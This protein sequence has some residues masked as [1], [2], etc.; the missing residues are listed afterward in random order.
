MSETPENDTI[1]AL[2]PISFLSALV[3]WAVLYAILKL[4][5]FNH[6]FGFLS[7]NQAIV[8][9]LHGSMF[10]IYFC[11]MVILDIK[12]FKANS[13]HGGFLLLL[14]YE[15]SVMTHLAISLNRLCAV[16][17]PHRYPNIFS[18]RNTKIIIAFIW[19]YTSSVAV[20]FYEVSCS[21][22][23]DEEI[24]FL[25]FSKTKL[26]GYIGWYGDLL[27][28]S[29]IVAIVMVLDM[30]TVVKVRKMSRKISAN[31]SDQAQNRLSQREMRFLKQTVTQ[32]TVF[33]LE[34][35]SYFFIPQYFVNKW[36]L[37]F[38]TSFAWVA[39][40]AL[41]GIWKYSIGRSSFI[42]NYPIGEQ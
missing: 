31:I 25:S 22:Y 38:A 23:F 36:I 17:V 15:I 13:N 7:A 20:L 8:D 18:E 6:S 39:V 32:G 41:D 14:S 29:T 3:N 27:K 34:L 10:L 30:L 35:L 26:C 12:S 2:L 19:F 42:Q 11:P 40:H 28:N 21:F 9:A 37:F 5:S 16:W 1:Y 33:M 4:K 24:Q